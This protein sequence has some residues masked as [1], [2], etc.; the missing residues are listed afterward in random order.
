MSPEDLGST[1]NDFM[2]GSHA[3]DPLKNVTGLVENGG[4]SIV[5]LMTTVGCVVVTIALIIAGI[6][7]ASL[8]KKTREEGK[9]KLLAVIVGA[10]ILF[11][12]SSVFLL[13]QGIASGF[14]E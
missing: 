2:T 4:S 14:M 12:L 9:E 3:S 11:G 6:K 5:R 1:L 7:I 10:I 8:N 13:V